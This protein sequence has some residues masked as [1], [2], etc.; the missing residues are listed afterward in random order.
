MYHG[1]EDGIPLLAGKKD[2]RITPVGRF[3]RKHKF[4]EIPNFINVLKG[5]MSIVGPRPEQLHF[6]RE[7]ILT[8]PEYNLVHEV[9]PG[10]TSW[11]IVKY[12][13]ASNPGEM[14]K[15]LDYDLEYLEN[16]SFMF[17]LKIIFHT[18]GIIIKGLGV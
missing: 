7:V 11:G 1:S 18:I 15:R 13:Y 16:R 10:I 12:G 3:M 17:D 9:K 14:I 6:I 2:P 8:T 4:D 5:D